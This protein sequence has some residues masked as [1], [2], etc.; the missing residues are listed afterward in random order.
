MPQL[1]R[2][3]QAQAQARP[4]TREARPHEEHVR[5]PARGPQ[6]QQQQARGGAEVCLLSL[7]I[8]AHMQAAALPDTCRINEKISAH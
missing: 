4:P 8:K 6:Q 3:A 7:L 1:Q 2:E 5:P